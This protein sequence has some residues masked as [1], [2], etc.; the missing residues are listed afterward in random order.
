MDG[1]GS[2]IRKLRIERGYPLRKVAAF[3][4]IDQAIL[5]K[6]E[7]GIRKIKKDQVIKLARFFDYDEKEMIKIYLSDR[8]L[9]ELGEEDT[10][11][12]ALKIAEEIIEYKTASTTNRIQVI[13]K[14]EEVISTFPEI[15]KAWIYGSFARNEDKPGSD[16]DIAVKSDHGF[17]Y[18]DLAGLQY[19]LEVVLKRKVDVG[20]IDSFKPRILAN[21]KRDMIQIYERQRS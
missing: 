16:I 13:E 3:L 7:R 20:F 10:A 2:L 5:S 19:R 15:I 21:V 8:I 12:E 1:V 17:S 18:F 6:M 11:L 14:I 9:Y 4:D